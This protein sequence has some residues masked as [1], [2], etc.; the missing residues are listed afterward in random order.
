MK[1]ADLKR[2]KIESTGFFFITFYRHVAKNVGKMSLKNV[3]KMSLKKTSKKERVKYIINKIKLKQ[4]FSSLT[5]AKELNVNEKTIKRDIEELKKTK[6]IKY[7]G[8]KRSGR[9][10]IIE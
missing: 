7:V 10:E 2:P 1:E 3:P 5:L 9:Y 8:S 6:K 4:L